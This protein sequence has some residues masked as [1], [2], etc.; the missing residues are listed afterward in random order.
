MVIG[1]ASERN[2]EYLREQ[3]VEPV[4]YGDGLPARV[5]ALAPDGVEGIVDFYGSGSLQASSSL[6]AR[7]VGAN[8]MV[9]AADRVH[10]TEIGARWIA[11]QP[12]TDDLSQLVA[13]VEEVALT[14]H[15]SD[16]L[17]LTDAAEANRESSNAT[18]AA[19]S[20]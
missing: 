9:T 18:L 8:Q 17:P 16:T 4:Q 15:V 1:T 6:L 20:S 2:H 19:R 11:V 5:R 10:A 3:G 7:G 13:W 12:D 14:V